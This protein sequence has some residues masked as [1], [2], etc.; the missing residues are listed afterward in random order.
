MRAHSAR[1]TS[2]VG[3]TLLLT[4][5]LAFTLTGAVRPDAL[6]LVQVV[7]GCSALAATRY[8][9][10]ALRRSGI[11]L[12]WVTA[13]LPLLAALLLGLLPVPDVLA[14]F[15]APGRVDALPDAEWRTLAASPDRLVGEL[16]VAGL[17]LGLGAVTATWGSV[18]Y[19]RGAVEVAATLLTGA[20]AVTALLH[21]GLGAREV[22]SLVTPE[23][24]PARFF[25]P[26]VN[27]SHMAATLILGLPVAT[28]LARQHGAPVWARVL[29]TASALA[30]LAVIAWVPSRGAW[31]VTVAVLG[32]MLAVAARS[33]RDAGARRVPRAQPRGEGP[34]GWAP[35]TSRRVASTTSRALGLGDSR[36]IPSGT[37]GAVALA[38]GAV[39]VGYAWRSGSITVRT[40]LWIDSLRL[41]ADHWFAGVGAGSFGS[42]LGAYRTDTTFIAFAHAH[43]DLLE[44]VAE[45]GLVG[46]LALVAAIVILPFRV[47][48][49]QRRGRGLIAGLTGLGLY[50]LGDFPFQVPA[51]ALGATALL[52]ALVSVYGALRPADPRRVRAVLVVV[53]IAQFAGAAWHARAALVAD[54]VTDLRALDAP[55]QNAT[56]I[57]GTRALD[58]R[59]VDALQRLDLLLAHPPERALHEARHAANPAAALRA[60]LQTHADD[61][62]LLRHAAVALAQTGSPTPS[63][64]DLAD[65]TLARVTE[66]DRADYRA[67][68]ARAR[69]AIAR[70]APDLALRYWVEA[71]RRDAPRLRDAYDALPVGVVWVDALEGAPPRYQWALASILQVEGSPTEALL[72]AERAAAR[73]PAAYGDHLF[74]VSI[75][76]A[77]DEPA[78][79]LAWLDGVSLRH[80][81]EPEFDG[82]R[83][84]LLERLGRHAESATAF[85]RGSR[86]DPRL[87]ARALRAHARATD[88]RT[89][90]ARARELELDGRRD[91]ETDLEIATLR[92]DAGDPQGCLDEIERR[93]LMSSS[94]ATRADALARTCSGAQR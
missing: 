83:G 16:S 93:D 20:L 50:S 47:V 80:P 35:E 70:D 5:G 45:T 28:T 34:L 49:T 56:R 72:A 75:Y 62:D 22:F 29:A 17:V 36:P 24:A 1:W 41:A 89:A 52:A 46:I 8:P 54:A 87:R 4:I 58:A 67:W 44:Y 11:T 43:D 90:L 10:D 84:D 65:R 40:N 6:A 59:V 61:P 57:D 60:L 13:S 53:A 51:I 74:R 19:Q 81:D 26:L 7:A 27:P 63:D 68:V 64:L 33:R 66:R 9:D 23:Q 77:M 39:I 38:L 82:R 79:A 31:L 18:R 25:A 30:A 69:L 73:D 42:M 21:A 12:R 2:L 78:A 15:L 76:V 55:R 37:V 14:G 94:V 88:A 92:R 32:T 71:F 86:K 85:Q 91:S 3:A 48:R